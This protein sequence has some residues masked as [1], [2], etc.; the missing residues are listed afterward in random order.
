M[1]AVV[2]KVPA[3]S[4]ASSSTRPLRNDVE[5][6]GLVFLR[7]S[8]DFV[9]F[10]VVARSAHVTAHTTRSVPAGKMPDRT[11]SV[12]P[13]SAFIEGPDD[14]VSFRLFRDLRPPSGSAPTS[15]IFQLSAEGRIA[16]R[17]AGAARHQTAA[18]ESSPVAF[19]VPY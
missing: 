2:L 16:P 1:N 8:L 10:G 9:I 7:E 17:P 4:L 18:P 11:M 19:V 6:D 13:A 5:H 12:C 15:A 14:R 3:M